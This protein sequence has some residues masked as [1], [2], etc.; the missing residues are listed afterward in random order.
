MLEYT[1]G[2]HTYYIYI[3]TNT[4]RTTLYI[5]VTNCLKRRLWE[6]IESISNESKSFVSRYKLS[7]LVYCEKFVWVQEAIAR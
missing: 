7:D 1:E 2:Y 4:Y 6:H 5:G 3:L